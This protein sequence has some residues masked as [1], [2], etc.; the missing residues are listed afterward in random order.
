MAKKD[1]FRIAA[2]Y[3][4]KESRDIN[5]VDTTAPSVLIVQPTDVLATNSDEA[6]TLASRAIPADYI[7]KL[8]EVSILVKSF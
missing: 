8:S 5:G 2:I 6:K 1:L 4:P 7:D 3:N